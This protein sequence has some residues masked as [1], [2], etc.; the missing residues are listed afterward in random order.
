[1]MIA[2]GEYFTTFSITPFIMLALVPINSSRVIPGLRGI[3]EVIPTT[4]E[5]HQRR[6]LV[7]IQHLTLRQ[8]LFDVDEDH[9]ARHFA[10]SHHIGAS[11]AYG[12]RAHNCYL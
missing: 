6:T 4:S 10:A 11:S 2:R 3:P 5:I 8:A 9:F 12:A 1:M 7:H